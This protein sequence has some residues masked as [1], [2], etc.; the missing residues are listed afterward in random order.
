[1]KIVGSYIGAHD[2]GISLIEN[3]K[4]VACYTEERFSRVKSAYAGAVFP[5]ESFKSIQQDFNFDINDP[6]IKFACAKPI[7]NIHEQLRN[8]VNNRSIKL[9]GHEYAHACGAYYTS[10]F[11]ENTLIVAYDGGDA[12]DD[13]WA[14]LNSSNYAQYR[15]WKI[16]NDKK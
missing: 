15:P 9:I 3:N 13:N 12:G 14:E 5:T 8:I 11:N 7:N 16:L 1:M 10:G 4:I 6:N 2:V